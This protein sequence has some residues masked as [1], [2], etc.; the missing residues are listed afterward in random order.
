MPRESEPA[1]AAPIH[2]NVVTR[3]LPR[4]FGAFF[5]ETRRRRRPCAWPHPY[6]PSRF[7]AGLAA[8]PLVQQLVSDAHAQ[9]AA[10]LMPLRLDIAALEDAEPA[11]RDLEYEGARY[12]TVP[13]STCFA[14]ACCIQTGL[15]HIKFG[16]SK[17]WFN[18][19]ELSCAYLRIPVRGREATGHLFPAFGP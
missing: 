10:A 13:S 19:D 18:S 17:I 5:S 15:R 11:P 4:R 2:A 3:F 14:S 1:G 7:D 8:W 6:A 12:V 9:T 16:S